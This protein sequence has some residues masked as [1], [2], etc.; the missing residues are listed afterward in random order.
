[1]PSRPHGDALLNQER[2][3]LI[4]DGGAS[5]YQPRPNTMHCLQVQLILAFLSN[6]AEVW[7][8][9]RFRNCFSIVVIVQRENESLDRF[10]IRFTLPLVEG[11]HI[12][13]RDDP[14]I[15]TERTQHAA[16]KVRVHAGFHA[17]DA[18]RQLLKG[19]L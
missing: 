18:R 10:L 8:H 6:C 12:D 14:G 19:R 16:D 11:L 5:R 2:P 9:S 1:M 17:D 4:D 3:D 7:A 15:K 13:R